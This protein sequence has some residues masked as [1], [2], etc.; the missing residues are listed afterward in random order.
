MRFSVLLFLTF[1]GATSQA[2]L[3]PVLL[4]TPT[5]GQQVLSVVPSYEKHSNELTLPGSDWTSDENSTTAFEIKY[6][7]GLTDDHSLSAG[8]LYHSNSNEHKSFIGGTPASTSSSPSGIKHLALGYDGKTAL[9]T[10]HLS[11]GAAYTMPLE[12]PSANNNPDIQSTL[13][14]SG[15]VFYQTESTAILGFTASYVNGLDKTIS[16]VTYSGGNS[17][18]STFFYEFTGDYRPQIALIHHAAYATSTNTSGT[19]TTTAGKT[20]YGPRFAMRFQPSESIE[21]TP[22][23][24]YLMLDNKEVGTGTYKTYDHLNLAVNC[25]LEF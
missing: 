1:V 9:E 20:T 17:L 8:L 3:Q 12:E 16:G 7:Y 25:R 4:E 13:V 18:E 21:I 15:G 5:A 10:V 11:Y 19:K 6:S 23:L 22:A 24:T 2:A 14:L